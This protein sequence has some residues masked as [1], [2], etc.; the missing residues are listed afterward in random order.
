MTPLNNVLNIESAERVVNFVAG[1]AVVA[2][3]AYN[4]YSK[5]PA[6][7]A[8]EWL[9]DA[10]LHGARTFLPSDSS[11]R[12]YVLPVGDAVRVFQILSLGDNATINPKIGYPDSLVH[13]ANLFFTGIAYFRSTAAHVKMH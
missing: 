3:F 12:K 13:I 11:I 4:L 8:A 9:F 1:A 10:T 6:I 2:G 7:S 5:G